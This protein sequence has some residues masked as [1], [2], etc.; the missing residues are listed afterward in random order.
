MICTDD[1][2]DQSR[3]R[4]RTPEELYEQHD[5]PPPKRARVRF[6][7][8]MMTDGRWETGKSAPALAEVW[9][10]HIN[11]VEKD[12]AEASRH[13]ED[14]ANLEQARAT[15]AT[16]SLEWADEAAGR[17]KYDSAG[18]LLEVHAKVA[19]A[20]QSGPTLNVAID[21][22]TGQLRPEVQR[23]VDDRLGKLVDATARAAARLGHTPEEWRAALAAEL[24]A[25]ALPEST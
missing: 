23:E 12:S 4:A 9:G 14:P 15:V 16:R 7:I 22:R 10:L 5:G 6:I 3:A 8:D 19:G 20:I 2:T 25:P 21:A 13:L 18:R 17:G 24:D 1:P 11:T